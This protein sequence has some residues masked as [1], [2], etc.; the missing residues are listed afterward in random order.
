MKNLTA[1]R[2]MESVEKWE[3]I[4]QHITNQDEVEYVTTYWEPCGFC[5]AVQQT[6]SKLFVSD[7]PCDGCSL[8]KKPTKGCG[9]DRGMYY[10]NTRRLEK[11]H[12]WATINNAN[13]GEYETALHHA[14]LVLDKIKRTK[15]DKG[16]GQCQRQK[17]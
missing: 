15:I 4:I 7:D 3:E 8:Y 14:T 16:V 2:K 5:E 10:C 12:A 17:R 6:Q 9:E 13:V 1:I 11:S